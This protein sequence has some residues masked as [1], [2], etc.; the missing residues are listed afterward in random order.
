MSP[1]DHSMVKIVIVG[2]IATL[3]LGR[4]AWR[5]RSLSARLIFTFLMLCLLIP[6]GMLTVGMNSWLL[7]ARY[8]TYREFYWSIRHD[9]TREEVMAV[10]KGFYPPGEERKSP[11]TVDN[12][13]SQLSF[14]M[15][16]EDKAEPRNET[17]LVRLE[18]GRVTGVD[19][20]PDHAE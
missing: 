4:L 10:M 3:I 12:S 15:D 17:I 16:P 18:A 19:Y 7:D 9:M 2:C 8:R 20:I 5:S 11:I 14:H 13:A 1:T 6:T